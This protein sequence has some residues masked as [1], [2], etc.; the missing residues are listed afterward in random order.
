MPYTI[1]IDGF[2]VYRNNYRSLTGIYAQFA[3]LNAFDRNRNINVFPI[4]LGPYGALWKDVV[5]SLTH[6]TQLDAGVELILDD[7]RCLILFTPSIYYLSDIPEQIQNS[8]CR[9][10]RAVRFC[11]SC[12]ITKSQG[13][14]LLFDTVIEGRYHF[15]M[16]RIRA[17]AEKKAMRPCLE[18]LFE[19]GLADEQTPLVLL[20]PALDLNN[21]R[22]ADSGHL[23]LKGVSSK[24]LSL[25][26]S[27]II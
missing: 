7:G 9:S 22:P 16:L 15:E 18:Q 14:D 8:G 25:L 17:E 23:K 10:A 3:F 11:R 27:D 12:R 1:F 20:T 6:L 4:T 26:F 21:T 2:G 19:E 24:A 13:G 5:T